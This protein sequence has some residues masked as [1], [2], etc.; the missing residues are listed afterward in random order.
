MDIPYYIIDAFAEGLFT[1]NPAGVCILDNWLEPELM[2]KIAMENNLSE[3][4]F[5]V[6]E[7]AG[8]RIRWFTPAVEVDL[9]GHATLATAHVLFRHVGIKEHSVSFMSRSGMLTV[10]KKG[11]F[12]VLDFPADKLK[13]A[14]APSSVTNALNI[15]PEETCKGISDYL[16]V[17]PD[18]EQVKQVRPN[19]YKLAKAEARG[20]II[21]A[22]GKDCDFVSRFFAPRVG[23]NED[24]VTGS[25][26]TLLIPYWSKRLG[27]TE[28]TAMQLSFR[29]G[30]LK[31][32]Y[33]GDRVEI[34]GKAFTYLYGEI[35][36]NC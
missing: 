1:G 36:I 35:K 26:H 8:Y 20:I 13:T 30:W 28:L 3:T 5:I 31:C 14:E 33:A 21:T 2:Q 18:E 17:L 22:P 29:R 6:K 23:V 19:F 12:L 7:P 32:R 9:C 4:A 25:A 27:K 15:T 10:M 11:E 34:G 16:I 24:P